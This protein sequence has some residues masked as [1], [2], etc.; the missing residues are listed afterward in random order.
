MIHNVY[1]NNM[2]YQCLN[3]MEY[4]SR[5]LLLHIHWPVFFSARPFY[6]KKLIVIPREALL[7][8]FKS[9]RKYFSTVSKVAASTSRQF[10]KSRQVL[11]DSFKSRGKYFST[12]SKVAASTS[13]QFQKSWQ[14]LLDSFKSPSKYFSTVSKDTVS[15]SRQF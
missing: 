4:K 6:C 14:V 10:Q 9:R 5:E 3:N 11:L 12:V 2:V 1:Y 7:S 13:R 15:T 8:S